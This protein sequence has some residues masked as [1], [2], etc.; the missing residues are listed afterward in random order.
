[1]KR[2]H[3]RQKSR[4][5]KERSNRRGGT[6]TGGEKKGAWPRRLIIARRYTYIHCTDRYLSHPWSPIHPS[7]HPSI[8]SFIDRAWRGADCHHHWSPRAQRTIAHHPA[9][10]TKS[11]F[12]Q[13]PLSSNLLSLAIIPPRLSPSLSLVSSSPAHSRQHRAKFVAARRTT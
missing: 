10:G 7:I 6:R 1:M 8:H 9:R 12:A 3:N 11:R 4:N 13:S 5:P 2:R